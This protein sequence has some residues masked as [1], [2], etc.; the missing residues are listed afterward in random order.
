VLQPATKGSS[1]ISPS[2]VTSPTAYD[3]IKMT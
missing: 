2:S 3:V 1:M